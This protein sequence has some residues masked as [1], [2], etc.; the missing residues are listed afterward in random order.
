M[1]TK[2]IKRKVVSGK[3]S[4]IKKPDYSVR[5]IRLF[6]INLLFSFIPVRTFYSNYL[7][8]KGGSIILFIM[9]GSF[10]NIT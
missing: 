10:E 5:I 9:S 3:I 2:E 8:V 1:L 7:R 4:F 6:P